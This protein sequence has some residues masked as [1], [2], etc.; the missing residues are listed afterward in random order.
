M[1]G[2]FSN[3]LI[4]YHTKRLRKIRALIDDLLENKN[5]VGIHKLRIEIK[6]IK[7]FYRLIESID[8]G[9][10]SKKRFRQFNYIA[11]ASND[12]RDLQ[13]ILCLPEI[14]DAKKGEFFLYLIKQR[15][16]SLKNF[17]KAL[18]NW[19]T[20]I[21]KKTEAKVKVKIKAFGDVK[22]KNEINKVLAESRENMKL[23]SEGNEQKKV[24]SLHSLRKL[25]K[26]QEHNLKLF[27]KM[28]DKPSVKALK[29]LDS[30]Q[31]AIGQWH[32]SQKT[33]ELIDN[34]M[35]KK[36]SPDLMISQLREKIGAT[37]AVQLEK[38]KALQ[39]K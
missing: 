6:K 18:K 39:N 34:F 26:E 5:E 4:K 37:I 22:I 31:N 19:D 35:K 14:N 20:N 21:L 13:V 33:L 3:Y 17:N 24:H 11:K 1:E 8:P 10:E 32:D 29:K 36:K 2:S 15:N 9:F 38:I 16:K 7:A 12:I 23:F 27:S 28:A 25:I 30:L